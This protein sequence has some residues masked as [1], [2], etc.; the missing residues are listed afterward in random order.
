MGTVPPGERKAA[1]IHLT[2]QLEA[3]GHGRPAEYLTWHARFL[4]AEA[5]GAPKGEDD[6]P[7]R[8]EFWA[9]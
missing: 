3:L 6:D 8:S 9:D 2:A 7:A 4:A 1:L 5:W